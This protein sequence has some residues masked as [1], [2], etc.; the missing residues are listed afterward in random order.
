MI[1]SVFSSREVYQDVNHPYIIAQDTG[2]TF[3]SLDVPQ[4]LEIIAKA[5]EPADL[6]NGVI[7]LPL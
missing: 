7:F 6:L 1:V 5:G 3:K 2:L 4:D